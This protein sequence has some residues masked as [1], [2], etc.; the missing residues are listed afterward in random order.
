MNII[1]WFIDIILHL[2]KH[3]SAMIE[4][5]G[6]W[7]YI[8][9]FTI[10]FLE[11]GIIIAPYL[12]GDSLIFAVG[13]FA[14]IGTFHPIW[15]FIILTLAAILGDSLNYAI[16]HYIGPKVFKKNYKWLNKRHLDKT[17]EFF[18]KYG[19]KT[20][21]LARFIPIIRTFAP[22]VAG[23]GSMEYKRFLT[24]NILGGILWVG[25]FFY[26]GFF[27]GNIPIIKNNFSIVIIIIILTSLIPIVIEVI[28][29]YREKNKDKKKKE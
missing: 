6:P 13:A 8:I 24:Y 17:H 3:L 9:L 1:L 29:Y 27:F 19:G 11:T 23:I 4:H 18:E 7:S 28:K 25:L 15:M 2:E 5:F 10:I 14:A 16:G 21:V 22:F 12:P 26:A 20:I